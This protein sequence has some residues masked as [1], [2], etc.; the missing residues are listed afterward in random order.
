[1]DALD[2]A[3]H[4]PIGDIAGTEAA[5]LL[6]DGNAEKAR[7][8][9]LAED[10]GVSVFLQI[11]LLNTWSEPVGGEIR[12]RITQHALFLGDLCFK[13]EGIRPV[14]MRYTAHARSRL[15]ALTGITKWA[16]L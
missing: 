1:I 12:R 13:A 7:F 16:R 11:S 4:K 8:A 9:H 2:L 6:R 5:I 15:H 3:G 14:K 10:G